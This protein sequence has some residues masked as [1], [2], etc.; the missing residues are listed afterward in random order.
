MRD[1]LNMLTLSL[2]AVSPGASDEHA[3]VLLS[4]HS[5]VSCSYSTRQGEKNKKNM[6]LRKTVV[7]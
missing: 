7:Y 3:E 6:G 5:K 4:K 1:P 2:L